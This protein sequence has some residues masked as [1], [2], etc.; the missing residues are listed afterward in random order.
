MSDDF[1]LIIIIAIIV[2]IMVCMSP[3]I[4]DDWDDDS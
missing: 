4:P 1:P 3:T 2:L